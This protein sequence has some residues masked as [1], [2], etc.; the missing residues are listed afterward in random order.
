MGR[1]F[2]LG[3]LLVRILAVVYESPYKRLAA[4][5]GRTPGSFSKQ[6]GSKDHDLKEETM[7]ILLAA[8]P[9]KPGAVPI[10]TDCL[11]GLQALEQEGDLTG[12][13][14]VE[15][16]RGALEASRTIRDALAHNLRRARSKP[17][18]GYPL[19]ADLAAHRFRAGRQIERLRNVPAATRSTV[20]AAAPEFHYWALCERA[21]EES[22]RQAAR[23]VEEALAWARLAQE[24]ANRV[25]GPEGWLDRLRGYAAAH[26]ANALRVAGE[27]NAA[28]LLLQEAK[29]HWAAGT[30]SHRV[31]DPGRLLDLEASLR[32]AQ[33]R[34]REALAL[35]EQAAA[36]SRNPGR[37]LIKMGFTLEV[38]GEYEQAGEALRQAFPLVEDQ[39]DRRLRNI[40]RLNLANNFCHLG[41]FREAAEMVNEVRPIVVEMGDKL[42]LIR[43][44]G[45]E[46]RIAAGLGQL[47]QALPLLTEA[48]R[49]FAGEK[50]F[51][52]VALLLLEE[53]VLLLRRGQPREVKRLA[54]ELTSVFEAQGVHREALAA[55]QL[56][57][58]AAEREQASEEL[59]Q[60]LLRYLLRARH[61][62][63]LRFVT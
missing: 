31:L 20:V 34:F 49:R 63:G 38:L 42:D 7:D 13:D 26:T 15:I 11:E 21:C 50:M 44:L 43:I 40:L 17:A 12:T 24:I 22:T 35:L 28:E 51:F 57:Q 23:N 59:A 53:A 27:L 61:D 18:P 1:R 8:I 58:Q 62:Q 14:N 54:G 36:V 16:S 3:Q 46:G 30:D 60:G 9:S 39:G 56:F 10:V 55:L 29:R 19:P 2:H 33:R 48:R 37:V 25:E 45:L 5:I 47:G 52:D 6:L 41:R 4:Q 32:R